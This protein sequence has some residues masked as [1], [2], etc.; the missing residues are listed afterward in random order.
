MKNPFASLF[1]KTRLSKL[2]TGGRKVAFHLTNADPRAA[3]GGLERY[4]LRSLE[5]AAH[6]K[7]LSA[8]VCFPSSRHP[9]QYEVQSNDSPTVTLSFDELLSE[10]KALELQSFHLQHMMNWD[11]TKLSQLC[12]VAASRTKLTRAYVHDYYFLMAPPSSEGP[13]PAPTELLDLRER[14]RYSSELL[15]NFQII[16]APSDTARDIFIQ[17]FPELASRVEVHPHFIIEDAGAMRPVEG[18]MRIV[19]S[20][21]CG[22]NKGIQYFQELIFALSARFR[23][24][25]VGIEDKFDSPGLVDH[26]HYNFHENQDLAEILESLRPAVAFMG[27]IVPETFSFTAH[28]MLEAGIPIITTRAS[29]NI[30]ALVKATGA[31]KSYAS[32]EEM[33]NELLENGEAVLSELAAKAHRYRCRWNDDA[34]RRLYGS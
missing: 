34:L 12:A 22:Y 5:F 23:W 26:V 32:F 16:S 10:V 31:G 24:A 29:G 7:A 13:A 6:D 14:R 33:K 8:F 9:D 17:G 15:S 25:T 30:S 4:V 18:K 11:R 3:P 20:G 28:E 1:G 21:A 2:P 19:F 27:S